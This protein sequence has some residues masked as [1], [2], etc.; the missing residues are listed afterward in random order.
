[1]VQ[2]TDVIRNLQPYINN[3]IA[4]CKYVHWKHY[5]DSGLIFKHLELTC[6]E[7]YSGRNNEKDL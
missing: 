6:A 1:M 3:C 2:R 4:T 7:N 5:V